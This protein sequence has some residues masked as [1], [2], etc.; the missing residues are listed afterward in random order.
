[1]LILE[2][3]LFEQCLDYL[4]QYQPSSLPIY[5]LIYGICN[6][7]HPW[8][9]SEFV[10]D[11]WPNPK[12]IVC[13]PIASLKN[14]HRRDPSVRQ[15][16]YTVTVWSCDPEKLEQLLSK[17]NILPWNREIMFHGVSCPGDRNAVENVC[18][19]EGELDVAAG[20]GCEQD[21][22][23]V[24]ELRPETLRLCS[25]DVP[26]G[27]TVGCLL[28]C[29]AAQITKQWAFG[30][31]ESTKHFL[32]FVLNPDELGFPSAAVFDSSGK[33]VS[34]ILFEAEGNMAMGYTD[35]EYRG[36]GFF[37]IV[38]YV[39]AKQ[40]FDSG[41]RNTYVQIAP[42]NNASRSTYIS[43]GAVDI[44]DWKQHWVLYRGR[45]DKSDRSFVPVTFNY[46]N[47]GFTK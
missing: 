40:L 1:M 23:D 21:C 10:V 3:E 11:Q 24:M 2:R 37:R 22:C 46:L 28:P 34:Y 20:N 47:E 15:I 9:G 25:L 30:G 4:R 16:C 35:K 29:H 38:N 18:L 14:A 26:V 7:N 42:G 32:E 31:N 6:K 45:K 39:L 19:R 5:Y 33:A 43:L 36:R 17:P 12:A 13:R 41:R 27:F 8:N 44:P